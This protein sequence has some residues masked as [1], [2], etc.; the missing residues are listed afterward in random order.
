MKILEKKNILFVVEE[1]NG[2]E[3]GGPHLEAAIIS[4]GEKKM[5]KEKEENNLD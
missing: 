2:K 5:E 4:R 1:K 3:K